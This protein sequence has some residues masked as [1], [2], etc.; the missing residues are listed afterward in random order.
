LGASRLCGEPGRDFKA[1]NLVLTLK[2]NFMSC[3][4]PLRVKDGFIRISSFHFACGCVGNI[5]F[6]Y[7]QV[8]MVPD[9]PIMILHALASGL[10]SNFSREAE[11]HVE[12]R[13]A[14]D[15]FAHASMMVT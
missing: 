13:L 6:T 5:H 3:Y 4:E 12:T 15:L 10:A 1:S 14:N 8:L 9:V 2:D 7:E 11:K